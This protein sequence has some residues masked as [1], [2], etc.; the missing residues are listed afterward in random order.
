MNTTPPNETKESQAVNERFDAL[1]EHYDG[2]CAAHNALRSM[3]GV[4]DTSLD[5]T[6]DY[7]FEDLSGDIY[8]IRSALQNYERLIKAS[9]LKGDGIRWRI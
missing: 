4:I 8:C 7:R 6:D 2:I 1:Q 9:G 3:A 5:E